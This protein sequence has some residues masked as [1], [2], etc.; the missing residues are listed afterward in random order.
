[1]V[2][3]FELQIVIEI[4]SSRDKSYVHVNNCSHPT[5]NPLVVSL[6]DADTTRSKRTNRWFNKTEFA[7]LSNEGDED[8]E[9]QQMVENYKN[10][11]GLEGDTMKGKKNDKKK[12]SKA[13]DEV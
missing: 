3:Y 11:G 1:M 5:D 9:L 12:K 10:I 2:S 8:I 4:A 6:E 13:K 7:G